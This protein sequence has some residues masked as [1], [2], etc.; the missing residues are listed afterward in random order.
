MNPVASPLLRRTS[1]KYSAPLAAVMT[2]LATMT[3]LFALSATALT[4]SVQRATTYDS[5]AHAYDSPPRV[6]HPNWTSDVRFQVR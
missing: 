6:T 4:T 1:G 2:L 5:A 3:V